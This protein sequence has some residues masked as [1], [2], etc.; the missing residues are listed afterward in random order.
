MRRL[1][2][3]TFA[4]LSL[5]AAAQAADASARVTLKGP[6]GEPVADAV[7]S[8]IPLDQ[9]APPAAPAG[10]AEVAQEDEQYQ[11]YLTIVRTGTTVEF[12]N[13]DRIQ[14]HLYSVSDAKK[15]EKPL[16]A[17]GAHESV[18]FDRPGVVTLGCNIHD[19]M[20]AYIVVVETPWFGRSGADGA[21]A[22]SAPAGRYRIEV[23]HP[24]LID[25]KTR[26]PAP[27]LQ[28]EVTL[29]ADGWSEEIA[30]PLAPDRRIRRAPADKSSRY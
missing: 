1:L 21:A 14:H 26:R 28:R 30:L 4:F 8:L 12:P 6:K 27:P 10:R 19:W 9:P 13:R 25:A 20:V 29:G 18:T 7:V 2:L 11:P 24:R 17:P 23:W 3:P 5:A 16:Y 15:F 22:V